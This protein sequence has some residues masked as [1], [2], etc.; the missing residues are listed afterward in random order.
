MTSEKPR[1]VCKFFL[2]TNVAFA[3]GQRLTITLRPV[4]DTVEGMLRTV[5]NVLERMGFRRVSEWEWCAT[6]YQATFEQRR[7]YM[8]TNRT[9]AH[10]GEFST[11][12]N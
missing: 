10:R 8:A 6:Y 12:V 11:V 2:R 3:R 5:S 9:E 7:Q 1:L 4:P